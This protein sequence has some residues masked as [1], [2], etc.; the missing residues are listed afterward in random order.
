VAID[1]LSESWRIERDR[2]GYGKPQNREQLVAS[3]AA[4]NRM[5]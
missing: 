1:S 3:L 2:P 5:P 4:A